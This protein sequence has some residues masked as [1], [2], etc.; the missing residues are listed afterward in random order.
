MKLNRESIKDREKWTAAGYSVPLYD[1]ESIRLNASASPKWV[2]FGAGNIFRA[3]PAAAWQRLLNTGAENCGIVV[4]EGFDHEI[5]EKMYA[6]FDNMCISVT[7][8]ADGNVD[9]SVIASVGQAWS[10]NEEGMKNLAEVFSK[11]SLQMITFTITEKGYGLKNGDGT[12]RADVAKDLCAGHEAA[13][14][15]M[16]KI[17]ALLYKR[18]L[19]GAFPVALV[20]MDNFSHNGDRL[21]A[22]VNEFV[23]SWCEAGLCD[24]GFAKYVEDRVTFPWTMIDKITPRPDEKVYKI[25]EDDGIENMATVITEKKTFGAPFVN[26]EET[27]YLVIEDD[28]PAGRPA[29]EKAGFLFTDRETVD[30][31]ERMKVCTCLNPLHTALAVFGCLLGYERIYEEMKDP[32]L[33]ELVEIIGYEEGLPVVTDPKIIEPKHFLEQVLEKRLANP[34]MPDTPQRI[35]TDTSQKLAAR[36]GETIKAYIREGKSLD[37]LKLISLVFAGWLRYLSAVDDNGTPMEVSPD[38]M[39]AELQAILKSGTEAD[40]S[41]EA[42]K[43]KIF[44]RRDIFGVDINETT[45]GTQIIAY[46]R[47]MQKGRGAVRRTLRAALAERDK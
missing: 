2:H 37:D 44:S 12:Y 45:M 22:A 25:L 33:R 20:S 18:F 30:R 19:G 16:G 8:K 46:F 24:K 43:E 39:A 36:F 35:A 11:E 7:L 29:L 5:I 47:L 34:Y 9:K 23:I 14:S 32:D 17:T 21:K 15:Y 41:D 38:P 40:V 13:E 1:I 10:M 26:A 6:P 3:F 31:A 28:F 27:E 42:I 4:A